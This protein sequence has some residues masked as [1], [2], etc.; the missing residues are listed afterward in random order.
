MKQV[1]IFSLL[2][3]L[4]FSQACRSKRFKKKFTPI[5]EINTEILVDSLSSS[6]IDSTMASIYSKELNFRYFS[7]KVTAEA[8]LDKQRNSFTANLRIVKDSL[9]W[10][11]ISPALGIEVAR[12]L[13]RK[14][15]VFFVNRLNGT[16]FA[17]DFRYINDLLKIETNYQ[18]IEAVLVAN[19]YLHYAPDKYGYVNLSN[20]LLLS[21]LKKRKLKKETELNVPEILFQELYFT[22]DS[23]KLQKVFIQ[24]HRPIRKFEANYFGFESI[25]NQLVPNR[26]NINASAEKSANIEL[27]YTKI[28]IDKPVNTPFNIPEGY[29]QMR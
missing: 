6:N 10:A 3:L 19:V 8:T 9:I 18:M 4:C 11:T 27:E 17:G 1:F 14:D 7:A 5:T 23:G 22:I 12:V 15:S 28:S 29:E 16:F 21:S 20:V 25:N 2:I 26:I 24:D 13:I